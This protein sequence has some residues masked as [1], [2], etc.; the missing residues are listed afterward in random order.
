MK[1]KEVVSYLVPVLFIL[2][3]C[4]CGATD[5]IGAFQANLDDLSLLIDGA[6]PG[7]QEESTGDADGDGVNDSDHDCSLVCHIPPGNPHK[8]HTLWSKGNSLKAHLGHGDKLGRCSKKKH[9][10]HDDDDDDDDHHD[11]DDD[12]D[13]DGDDD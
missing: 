5:L 7:D 8:S 3:L 1:P 11:D 10:G 9:G 2:S 4:A 13:D 6:Q 12:D